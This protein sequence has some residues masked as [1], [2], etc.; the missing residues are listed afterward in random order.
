MTLPTADPHDTSQIGSGPIDSAQSRPSANWADRANQVG[1]GV[2]VVALAVLTVL[3]AHRM[4]G[5]P[6]QLDFRGAWSAALAMFRSTGVAAMRVWTFWAVATLVIATILF[7]FAPTLGAADALLAGAAGLWPLAFIMGSL[8]GPIGLWRGPVIWLMLA[9]GAFAAWRW[10]P[11]L[12]LRV[13]SSGSSWQPLARLASGQRL[14]LLAFALLAVGMVPLALASPVPPF[15]DVLATPS[16]VQRILNFGVYLPFDNNP[17]G[18]WGPYSQTPAVDLFY[19]ALA[20]GGGERIAAPAISVAMVPMAALLIFATWRLGRTLFNDTTG[21]MA[22]LLLVLTCLFRRTQGMRGTAVAFVMVGLGLAFFLD[23]RRTPARL[24]L[25][26][27]FLGTAVAS[28]AIDGVSAMIVAGI[29]V[30]YI[31]ADRGGRSFLRAAIALLGSLMVAAPEFPIASA[32]PIPYPIL[33]L[34]QLAGVAVIIAAARRE[35]VRG[36]GNIGLLQVVGLW[37][38]IL[39]LWGVVL[40]QHYFHYTIYWQVWHNQ[41]FILIL[42]FIGLGAA[43]WMYFREP[44]AM[45]YAGMAAAALMIGLFA[46]YFIVLSSPFIHGLPARN[47]ISE[48]ESKTWDYWCPWC[49]AITAGLAPALIYDRV[50]RPLGFI[51]VMAI[52][53]YPWQMNPNANDYDSGQHSVVEQWAFNLQTANYGYWTGSGDRR[54]TL[55]PAEFELVRTLER[56][57]AAGRITTAT[58]IAHINDDASS[59]TLLQYPVFTGIDDDPIELNHDPNNMW[60]AGSRVR[61]PEAI[62]ELGTTRPAYIFVQTLLPPGTTLPDGYDTIYR[63]GP[64]RLLRRSDLK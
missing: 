8:A 31:L 1:W 51:F 7:H 15:M 41:P 35:E 22:A 17:Y 32:H 26:A 3:A 37:T 33:P 5:F 46:E 19:S 58:H 59:W 28:H 47:M 20:L 16:S 27:I 6:Y 29:G 11:A 53:I 49:L 2:A 64:M 39:L 63:E 9:A 40:R 12:R 24:A 13:P 18:C 4:R 56:E 30:L 50:S 48:I 25:G 44:V 52:I 45:P 61:G 55:D 14:A 54:W 62:A 57:A 42:G 10:R 43:L 21:G 34:V 23:R 36:P 38:I 60:T